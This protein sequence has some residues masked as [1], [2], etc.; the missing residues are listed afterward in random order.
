M[1]VQGND[2]FLCFLCILNCF[3][4]DD[5]LYFIPMAIQQK[6]SGQRGIAA[7]TKNMSKAIRKLSGQDM[8]FD[9]ALLKTM[10]AFY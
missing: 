5:K 9:E 10:E 6:I 1:K 8:G 3:E 4:D 7:A 2:S